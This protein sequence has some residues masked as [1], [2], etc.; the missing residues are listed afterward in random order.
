MHTPDI[1][2]ITEILSKNRDTYLQDEELKMQG[3]DHFSNMG[4]NCKRGV[5]IYA[6]E[7][8]NATASK[9]QHEDTEVV[10]AGRSIDTEVVSTKPACP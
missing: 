10:R 2:G 4:N 7:Q 5:I 9:M 3:Y 6:R 1:I 8:L